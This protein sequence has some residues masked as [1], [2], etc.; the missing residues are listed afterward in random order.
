MLRR[1]ALVRTDVTGE[2]SASFI[3]V[4]RIGELGTTLAVRFLQEPHRVTSQKT[5]SFLVAAVKTSDLTSRNMVC[6]GGLGKLKRKRISSIIGTRTR[7]L[8]ACSIEPELTMAD[9]SLQNTAL[10]W[11]DTNKLS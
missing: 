1:V 7:D 2:L 5:Q 8:L 9:D 4:T 3:R 6:L 10:Y 11:H